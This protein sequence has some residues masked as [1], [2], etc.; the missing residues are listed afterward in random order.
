M[1]DETSDTGTALRPRVEARSTAAIILAAGRSSRMG[2]SKALLDVAGCPFLV[3]VIRSFRA[4]GCD[5][6]HV[7]SGHEPE[8]LEQVAEAE[9]ARGVRNARHAEG[10]ITSLTAG[11]RSLPHT[12]E[13]FLMTPVDH[14]LFD[15]AP[16]RAFLGAALAGGKPLAVPVSESGRRGHPL[17]VHRSLFPEFLAIE[18]D[19]ESG[20]TARDVIRRDPARVLEVPGASPAFYTNL[21]E[22]AD[23][24]RLEEFLPD[25]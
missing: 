15:P 2:A 18:D 11:I 24:G 6:V 21:N 22:P 14:P 25:Y 5:P 3:R 13:G 17:F 9:F 10:Q 23:L 20:L 7:V 16:V 12:I 19:P 8:L 4:A 1:A